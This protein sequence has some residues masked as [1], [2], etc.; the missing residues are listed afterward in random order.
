MAYFQNPIKR[1]YAMMCVYVYKAILIN[2]YY[3]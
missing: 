3:C 1:Q 2:M